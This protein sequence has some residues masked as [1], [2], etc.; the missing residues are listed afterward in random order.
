MLR[1]KILFIVIIILCY[2]SFTKGDFL[3][4]SDKK[5]TE[6]VYF[7]QRGCPD[8]SEMHKILEDIES[9]YNTDIKMFDTRESDNIKLFHKVSEKYDSPMGIPI[10][11]V[12]EHYLQEANEK[13]LIKYIEEAIANNAPSPL[14]GIDYDDSKM[15]KVTIPAVIGAAAVDAFNPCACAVLAL[16]LGTILLGSKSK[17][18][19]LGAGLAFTAATFISYTLMGLGLL[20]AIRISS[21]QQ[22]IYLGASIL[23]IILGLVN[24]KDYFNANDK[25]N[26]EVPDSWK[27]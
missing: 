20:K 18:K 27:G 26:I 10:V 8:C 21:V 23:A 9:E 15:K 5:A 19:V 7:Y 12:G 6:I 3:F 11:F 4:G 16:L 2:Y 13:L 1:N 17:K 14:E 22:Y 24:M 25:F